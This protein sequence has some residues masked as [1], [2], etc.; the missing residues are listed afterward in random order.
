[1]AVAFLLGF[2]LGL[3]ALAAAEAAALL[4][5]I[6]SLSRRKVA[7]PEATARLPVDPPLPCDKEGS[8]W[9]L[10]QEKLPK[11]TRNRSSAGANQDIKEK[12]NIVEVFPE[13]MLAKLKG[14]SLCLSGLDG[15][16][17]QITIE[18]LNC[19]VVAVSAS[20]LSSRKWAKRYPIKLE[21]KGSEIYKGSKVCYVYADTSW[22]K[23]SWCKALRL[24]T[25]A[26]KEKLKFHAMLIEEFRSYISSLNAG[27]PCFLKSS[28][29]SGE[30]HVVT[31]KTVKTDGSS[32]V[33]LFLKK[34][35]K[36]ASL[37][38]SPESTKN[39]KLVDEGTLCCNLLLSRFFFDVKRND[40]ITNAIKSRIQRTLSNTRTPAYIGE[41]TLSDLN[42]GELPPYL[43]RMRILPQDLNEM[44]A[45]EVD[46]EYSSRILLH[47][48][49]RLEVQ[50]PELQK[51]IMKTTLKDD[52]NADVNSDLLDSIE[53]YGNQFRSSQGLSSATEDND[54]ADALRKSKS[55]GW[56]STYMPRWKSILHSI[57]DHVSQVPLSLAIKVSS[58]R[59]TMRIHI[60]PPPTDQI[61]YGF[62][63]MPELEWELESSVGDRKISNS[64][65]ASS[66]TGSRCFT[67]ASLHQT[68]VLPNCES[69]PISWMI[70]D[71]DDWVPRKV[72]PFI[73]L[74][75]EPHAENAGHS[76]DRTV[77][78]PW[79]GEEHIANNKANKSSPSALST[80]SHESPKNTVSVTDGQNEGAEEKAS[81]QQHPLVSASA[82]TLQS[83]D[84]NYQLRTPLL[85]SREL[86][87]GASSERSVVVEAEDVKRKRGR[88]ARVIDLGRRMGDKLEEKGKHIVDKMRGSPNLPDLERATT[89][90]A[91]N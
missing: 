82:A 70:S 13:K 91:H 48:E 52:S 27:Y 71:K 90:Y 79:P 34:F 5:A 6:R 43:R 69:I 40:E 30:E 54:A 86:Q 56:T 9:M 36:E 88:R 15:S 83:G 21:S 24:A 4:W 16:Q 87:E 10:E 12:K 20:N 42:L 77:S 75:R 22:E 78:L 76:A 74:N 45:F 49:T 51:D 68:L 58:V 50:E 39:E 3:V 81:T 2:L 19:T 23:E 8:L 61:W 66:A 84:A 33:R 60:K 26:D 25:T 62:T 37:K 18:L 72:A 46:F 80:R 11:V 44:W 59:G 41:I 63:S 32:K 85:S 47:I 65:I 38:A 57:A 29:L 89:A 55:S 28:G 73:W 7:S 53:H 1:M 14:H 35:A 17:S 64:R 67:R 31:N